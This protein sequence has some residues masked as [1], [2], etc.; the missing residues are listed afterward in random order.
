MGSILQ[1]GSKI[2]PGAKAP[3]WLTIRASEESRWRWDGIGGATSEGQGKARARAR[4]KGGRGRSVGGQGPAKENWVLEHANPPSPEQANSQ[5][6]RES[7]VGTAMPSPWPSSSPARGS[8]HGNAKCHREGGGR[9]EKSPPKNSARKYPGVITPVP[10]FLV[11]V[12]PRYPVQY[13]PRSENSFFGIVSPR[14]IVA[15]SAI[16]PA[17]RGIME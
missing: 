3:K 1:H 5:R 11:L 9:L 6:F 4:A 8:R 10:P 16:V 13:F 14:W 17:I 7:R 2:S 15:R 12:N